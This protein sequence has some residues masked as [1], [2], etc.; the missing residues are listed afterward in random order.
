MSGT[1]PL[2]NRKLFY[3]QDHSAAVLIVS[4]DHKLQKDIE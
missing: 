3:T 2:T 1:D 4:T